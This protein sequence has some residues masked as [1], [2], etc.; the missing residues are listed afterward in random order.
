MPNRRALLA[1]LLAAPAAMAA[2][3]PARAAAPPNAADREA[4]QRVERYLNGLTTIR[5]RFL[6]IA[7]NGGSAEGV[8]MIWR[9][10]RMR[11]DY[12]PPEP[13]LL[14]ADSGQFLQYDRELRQRSIVP[15]GS[16]PLGVLLRPTIR[17]T[18]ADLAVRSVE[19]RGGILR[20]TMQNASNPSEGSLTLVFQEE[21]LELRQW[22]V[23]DAQNRETRVSLSAIETGVRLDSSLFAINDPRFMEREA[24]R[25]N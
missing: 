4:I 10:G 8:A 20:L 11:F 25:R 7:Q 17:L 9:P 22:I 5:A 2:M 18:G 1:S 24:E 3:R 21:P 12:D 23:V 16:T 13:L 15:V 19:S 14:V 6:Q